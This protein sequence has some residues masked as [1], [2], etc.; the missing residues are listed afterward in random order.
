MPKDNNQKLKLLFL[1]KIMQEKTD[2]SHGLSSADIISLLLEYGIKVERKTLYSDIELLKDFGV[3]IYKEH[4]GRQYY[5]HMGSREFELPELKLLVDLVQ[6]SKFITSK[7]SQKLIN[8]IEKLTSNYEATQ[9]QRQVYVSGRVKA[10]NEKIYYAVDLIHNAINNDCRL[11]FQYF[12]WNIKKEKELRH[13]GKIYEVSPWALSW[14]NEKYYLIGYDDEL[15][16]IRHYRVDKIINIEISDK[17]RGGKSAFDSFD[18]SSYSKRIFGM[19]DGKEQ[20]VKLR[21]KNG[22]VGVIIDRFGTDINIKKIDNT[23]FETVVDVLVSEQFLGWIIA[24]GDNVKIVSPTEVVNDMKE[25]L[26]ERA[27]LYNDE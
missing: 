16:D 13:N 20:K 1:L 10:E 7:K 14:D 15:K 26:K 24:L 22:L 18:I 11:R 6:S 2:D 9:L 8:K 19:Y 5:Y 12:Q 21:V 17:K 23:Y 25:M 3:D 4:I 27:M